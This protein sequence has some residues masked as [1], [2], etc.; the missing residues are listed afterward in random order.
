MDES[1]ETE[2]SMKRKEETPQTDGPI[3]TKKLKLEKADDGEVTPNGIQVNGEK[4][5][6]DSD[7]VKPEI[8]GDTVKPATEVDEK[9]QNDSAKDPPPQQ[10]KTGGREANF[11]SE[12]F[13][14]EI[15]GLP[16]HTGYGQLKK[17]LSK[18]GLE[19]KKVK[20]PPGG[21]MGALV[22]FND[23]ENRQRALKVLNEDCKFKGRMLR[24]SK[25]K[26]HADPYEKA[27]ANKAQDDQRPLTIEELK[28]KLL[29]QVAP[30]QSHSYEEQLRQKEVNMTA[31]VKNDIENNIMKVNEEISN[32]IHAQRIKNLQTL[33]TGPRCKMFPI[34]ASPV[35]A[36]Y[37]NKNEFTIGEGPA[38]T[39]KEL[40]VG[41]RVGSYSDGTLTVMDPSECKV[42]DTPTLTVAQRFQEFF[43]NSEFK[44]FDN[45]DHSGCWRFLTVRTSQLGH[46]MVIIS[47][48]TQ[49][50]S[51]EQLVKVK[52]DLRDFHTRDEALSSVGIRS[53]YF[54]PVGTSNRE[55]DQQ[56]DL[57]FGESTIEE[58]LCGMKFRISPDAFFQANAKGAE[59]LIATISSWL[60]SDNDSSSPSSSES[61]ASIPLLDV[62]CG[63]GTIGLALSNH[64]SR[65]IGI[66][67]VEKAIEDA[68][69][70]ASLNDVTNVEFIAGK[71]EDVLP[72]MLESRLKD[73]ESL[74]AVVDPPRAGLHKKVLQAIR[75]CE[76]I[77]R[78]IYVSCDPK[79]AKE[80]FL[81]LSRAPSKKGFR[82]EPFLPSKAV[83]I[84]LFPQTHHC[85]LVILFERVTPEQVTEANEFMKS[86]DVAD[87]NVMVKEEETAE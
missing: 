74:V 30:L 26:A 48:Y 15:D 22:T 16:R 75:K 49:Q 50:L 2:A 13:K 20:L 65:V 84:D 25:C 56:F 35:Q 1:R 19:P 68:K 28:T 64:F 79:K 43:R 37:R 24:A 40:T 70:N 4:P 77:K 11:T 38:I 36:G 82:G 17:F 51:P 32:I 21:N 34:V 71:A 72:N 6:I 60:S 73:A 33:Q 23:E 59:L 7:A 12:I 47:M 80:D 86:R 63:T 3:E 85:E 57:L 5:A 53:L 31:I 46:V 9:T 27:Q 54:S 69:Q 14:I 8:V 18:L 61:L 76:G 52:Q 55:H 66:E 29:Q 45:R 78:F 39:G 67:C 44:A 10:A 81:D 41:F 58:Q 87:G 62:C 42:L 83:P